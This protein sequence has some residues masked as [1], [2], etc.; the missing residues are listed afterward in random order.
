VPLPCGKLQ[1][2]RGLGVNTGVAL[3]ACAAAFALTAQEAARV[4][5]DLTL[6]STLE[7]IAAAPDGADASGEMAEQ[8][9][10]SV[11]FTNATAEIIDSIRIT[12]AVPSDLKYVAESAS[13][14][15]S[16][17]LFSVDHGMRFGRPNELTATDPDGSVRSADPADYTHVRWTLRAPLDAGATGIARFRAVPR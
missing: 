11:R 5:R 1:S 15:G 14:P 3:V 4:P 17:V 13:G 8:V 7:R 6:S 16:D 12:S 9:I 2:C 10:V